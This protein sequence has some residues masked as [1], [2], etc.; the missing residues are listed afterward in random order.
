[1]LVSH[2]ITKDN[3]SNSSQFSEEN[4][5]RFEIWDLFILQGESGY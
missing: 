1:M 4:T 5:N 2:D 3:A